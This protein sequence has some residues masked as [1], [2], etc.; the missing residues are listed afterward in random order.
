MGR[1]RYPDICTRQEGLYRDENGFA[2][3]PCQK[4]C[5]R[6]AGPCA[7]VQPATYLNTGTGKV[8]IAYLSY[9]FNRTDVV[10]G[11]SDALYVYSL[12]LLINCRCKFGGVIRSDKLDRNRELLEKHCTK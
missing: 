12:G 1:I 3:L 4:Y 11:V 9:L 8:W 2:Y 7:R 6:S 10:L 5:R